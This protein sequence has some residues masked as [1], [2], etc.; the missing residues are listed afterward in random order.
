MDNILS[1]VKDAVV[2]KALGGNDDD[3]PTPADRRHSSA[4]RYDPA[5]TS[6]RHYG[7]GE[8]GRRG[9][10]QGYRGRYGPMAALCS[11]GSGVRRAGSTHGG[12]RSRPHE[13]AP[14]AGS[15]GDEE[16]R[17]TGYGGHGGRPMARLEDDLRD[18][19][20]R[21]H[22]PAQGSGAHGMM[23]G[24]GGGGD[25]SRAR[26]VAERH[27]GGDSSLFATA[28]GF[29]S[30]REND[31]ERSDVDEAEFVRSHRDIYG[32]EQGGGGGGGAMEKDSQVLAQAAAMQALKAFTGGGSGGG[33]SGTGAGQDHDA[34]IG[35]A[36]AEA[37]K[38]FDSQSSKGAV[39][40]CS[41]PRS[42]QSHG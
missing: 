16:E 31:L 25:Y 19:S 4:P 1:K 22:G 35:L 7:L 34:F 9:R 23:S 28:L 26:E 5:S 29:L 33:A 6:A 38:L 12:C 40:C 37:A 39:V 30:G 15:Y 17:G 2:D 41:Q 21:E 24:G 20:V 10:P 8:G 11:R 32:G 13:P 18:L 14:N 27:A 36:M 3:N 42:P